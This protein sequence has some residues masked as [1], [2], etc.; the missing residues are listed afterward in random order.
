MLIRSM[1]LVSHRVPAARLV[2]AGPVLERDPIVGRPLDYAQLVDALGLGWRVVLAGALSIGDIADLYA[3]ASVLVNPKV[4]HP[5]NQMAA[6]IKIGEYLAAGRPVLTTRVC[7]LE[8][9]LVEG[10]D[11]LF[12]GAG[13]PEALA[14][15]ICQIL[16]DREVAD[17][18]SREGARVAR[19][20]CDY[21]AWGMRVA[22]A[23]AAGRSGT[24]P[25]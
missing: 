14:A 17:R 25:L 7:E 1:E 4:D 19:R 11:V 5:T 23:I 15:K 13:D 16:T 24:G 21:R 18:L 2:V 9:W 20:A 3:A 8:G 12:C 22:E 10:Q 6:P